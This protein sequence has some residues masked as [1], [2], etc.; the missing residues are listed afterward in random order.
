MGARYSVES[1]AEH[2]ESLEDPT[3]A[4]ISVSL[5]LYISKRVPL[6]TY[7]IV[8][9]RA[10]VCAVSVWSACVRVWAPARGQSECA[11]GRQRG[12]C[13]SRDLVPLKPLLVLY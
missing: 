12:R 11:P 13:L 10:C 7:L 1:W 2:A 4:G 9:T 8:G 3:P 6:Y 5:S